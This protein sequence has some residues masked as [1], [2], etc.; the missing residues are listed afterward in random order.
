MK[1]REKRWYLGGKK[2]SSEFLVLILTQ[3]SCLGIERDSCLEKPVDK[4]KNLQQ[5]IALSNKKKQEM[6]RHNNA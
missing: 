5:Q 4:E 2:N 6:K 3:G 1:I